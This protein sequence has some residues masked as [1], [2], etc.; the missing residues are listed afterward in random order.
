MKAEKATKILIKTM[1]YVER[2]KECIERRLDGIDALS[3][4]ERLG[5]YL[6]DEK[7]YQGEPE[8]C[9]IILVIRINGHTFNAY[10]CYFF[11]NEKF[12]TRFTVDRLIE[13]KNVQEIEAMDS[14]WEGKRYSVGKV[15]VSGDYER[16]QYLQNVVQKVYDCDVENIDSQGMERYCE[17]MTFK[18]AIKKFYFPWGIRNATLNISPSMTLEE[19]ASTN[20]VSIPLPVKVDDPK[21]KKIISVELDDKPVVGCTD[22]SWNDLIV[23]NDCADLQ[24]DDYYFKDILLTVVPDGLGAY[25]IGNADDKKYRLDKNSLNIESYLSELNT[26]LYKTCEETGNK[27][28][29]LLQRLTHDKNAIDAIN[30]RDASLRRLVDDAAKKLDELETLLGKIV[31]QRDQMTLPE[32]KNV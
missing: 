32:L 3:W 13:E 15:Y 22:L 28:D 9:D 7:I 30:E 10:Y 26:K 5:V 14:L 17:K 2:V 23:D 8:K 31:K 27:K 12:E 29:R 25:Y 6:I 1:E 4:I 18:D 21:S 20:G 16:M 19:V 24:L 11:T